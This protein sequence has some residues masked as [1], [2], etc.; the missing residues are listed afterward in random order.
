MANLGDHSLLLVW[1][2]CFT[3]PTFTA[4]QTKRL[5]SR[6]ESHALS[7]GILML[8]MRRR[9]SAWLKARPNFIIVIPRQ[10][11][12]CLRL[13]SLS[14]SIHGNCTALHVLEHSSPSLSLS[15]PQCSYALHFFASRKTYL[16]YRVCF[17]SP[18]V[19]HDDI[20]RRTLDLSVLYTNMLRRSFWL[21]AIIS[22]KET[23]VS[24]SFVSLN[25]FSVCILLMW[26]K[27]L[28]RWRWGCWEI[29]FFGNLRHMS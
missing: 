17:F 4:L 24:D 23:H 3:P 16:H 15:G 20:L 6:P 12:H 5:L 1:A 25:R 10:L 9:R 14:R 13:F 28:Q 8:R 29:S 7:A 27:A 18:P 22:I 2:L 21:L 26:C 19:F 11:E